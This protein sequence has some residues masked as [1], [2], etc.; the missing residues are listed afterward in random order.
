M[1]Q[2]TALKSHPSGGKMK[3]HFC[4]AL[5]VQK[6]HISYF[7]EKTIAVCSACHVRIHFTKDPNYVQYKKGDSVFFYSMKKRLWRC[8]VRL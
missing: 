2:K 3:C 8:G 4:E 5:A 1:S 6:H 7:P